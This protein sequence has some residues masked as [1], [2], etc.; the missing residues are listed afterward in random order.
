MAD[1]E[2]Y[3]LE[4]VDDEGREVLETVNKAFGFVP[5]LMGTMVES[6]Q[7]AQAYLDIGKTFG[8]TSFSETEQQV[9][10]LAVSRYHECEY[11]VAAHSA[12]AGMGRVPADVVAAI[13]NDEPIADPKLEALRRFVTKMAGQRGR[14]D[15]ADIAEFTDAGYERRQVLEVLVG[16][17]MKTMSNFTNHIAGTELDGAFRKHEWRTPDDRAA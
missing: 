17:A 12:I 10:L 9:V 11:C 14:V 8:E 7:L 6:P 4:N 2:T 5:N 16:L 13:R 3:S 1:F 15:D